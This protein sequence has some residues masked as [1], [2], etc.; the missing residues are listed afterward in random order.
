VIFYWPIDKTNNI[1]MALHWH[2]T[3]WFIWLK[4]KEDLCIACVASCNYAM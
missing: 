4:S 2:F 3:S 1:I